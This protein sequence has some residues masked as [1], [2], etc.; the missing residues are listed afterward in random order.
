MM[1]REKKRKREEE[2]EGRERWRGTGRGRVKRK[3]GGE[4]RIVSMCSQFVVGM[5]GSR[6]GGY[7]RR[8]RREGE[9]NMAEEREGRER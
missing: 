1:Q 7:V 5:A 6:G 3:G 9:R 4:T 8:H 2:S